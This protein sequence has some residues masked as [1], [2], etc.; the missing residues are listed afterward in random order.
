MEFVDTSL[1]AVLRG[2]PG[3]GRALDE[4]AQTAFLAAATR[5]RVKGLLAW[6]LHRIGELRSW[7]ASIR[8]PLSSAARAEAALEVNRRLELCRLVA[9]FG[10]A[11]LPLL[12]FK[13]AALAYSVYPEPWLRPREDTDL[14]I[15]VADA[16]RARAVLS[17]AGYH[18][19]P[20]QSG[21]LVSH[22]RQYVRV[23]ASGR[24]FACDLHWKI[25][26]PVAFADLRTPADLFR[27]SVPV[28]LDASVVAR[29]P[30]RVDA[31]LLACWHRV[32]HHQDCEDLL[33]LYDLHLLA[34]GLSVQDAARLV[35]VAQQTGTMGAVARGMSLAAERFGTRVPPALRAAPGEEDRMAPTAVYLRRD[36][37]KVDLLA[38]D[39]RALPDWRSRLR[40]VREHL[41]PPADYMFAV[42]GRSHPALLPALYLRR[43]LRGSLA[44]FRRPAARRP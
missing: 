25:A 37:R 19:L 30:E 42:S 12:L 21:E 18:P 39:L 33:W 36:A 10:L 32:S 43:I 11:D 9:A 8:E 34:D 31:V 15:D 24:R 38:A 23:D 22:Q 44:W 5:H 4:A 28:A 3:I 20:M 26:N 35:G 2:T 7:P 13:G 1:C 16:A 14:L 29:V 40:L 41:F 17:G 27:D 6:Q